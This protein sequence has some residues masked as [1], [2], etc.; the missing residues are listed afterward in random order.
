[1][2]PIIIFNTPLGRLH[3]E[4][5]QYIDTMIHIE[6]PPD[7]LVCWRFLKDQGTKS[8]EYVLEEIK[9]YL[10]HSRILNFDKALKET[11]DVILSGMLSPEQELEQV[12]AYL[13]ELK[14]FTPFQKAL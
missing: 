12:M 4:T 6:V 14:I 9:F 8:R 11:V 5:G 3:Q 1:M 13:Q 2:T 10:R 7:V